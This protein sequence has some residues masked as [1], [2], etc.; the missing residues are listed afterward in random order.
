MSVELILEQ[1]W[2]GR[3]KDLRSYGEQRSRFQRLCQEI[4]AAS[5]HVIG[6]TTRARCYLISVDL[7][8]VRRTLGSPLLQAA[9]EIV[10]ENN[11]L[12]NLAALTLYDVLLVNPVVDGMS[13]TAKEGPV[14]NKQAGVLVLSEGSGAYEQL[15][16]GA[17][18]VC[19]SDLE[20]TAQ[21]LTMPE[22]ER[23]RRQET[24][25][26]VIEAEDPALWLC[27]Q[28]PD[29]LDLPGTKAEKGAE[30]TLPPGTPLP[31]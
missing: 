21:A 19:P 27:R 10:H 11:Y 17:L 15:R 22:Q 18:T 1:D 5:V 16:E 25:P 30:G 20:G 24:L 7:A 2:G 31:E 4:L 8:G 14:A 28:L 23:C 12:H 26:R 13:L 29:L 3:L 6:H 9:V